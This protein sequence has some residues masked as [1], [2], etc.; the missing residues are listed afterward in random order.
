VR[1]LQL[2][3]VIGPLRKMFVA[4]LDEIPNYL[5]VIFVLA[6][7]F[8]YD[9]N[10]TNG[11]NIAPFTDVIPLPSL[12]LPL[13]APFPVL[14]RLGRANTTPSTAADKTLTPYLSKHFPRVSAV[15]IP[16]DPQAPSADSSLPLAARFPSSACTTSATSE[17]AHSGSG[18]Q[19]PSGPP[20][21]QTSAALAPQ[22]TRYSS[23]SRG[24][25]FI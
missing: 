1:V 10:S 13:K 4:I 15:Q 14:T 22:C 20:T 18:H 9:L 11:T 19:W 16:L 7:F 6:I 8:R 5:N 24:M 3:K 2:I 21:L 25:T 23:S 12:P 17:R